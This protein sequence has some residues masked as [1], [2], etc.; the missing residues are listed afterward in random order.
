[1]GAYVLPAVA[2]QLRV[3]A[4]QEDSSTQALIVEAIELLFRDRGVAPPGSRGDEPARKPPEPDLVTRTSQ[5]APAAGR[6]VHQVQPA[7]PAD[8]SR[9][10]RRAGQVVEPPGASRR[11]L[12]A[13]ISAD[14]EPI[15]TG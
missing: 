7:E 14:A 1:V 15:S 10:R 13:R 2:R 4:G 5:A 9:Q 8:T 6:H 11:R 3:I 12:S